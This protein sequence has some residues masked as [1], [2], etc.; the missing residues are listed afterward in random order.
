MRRWL[1]LMLL[2]LPQLA[3][4]AGI[5][6]ATLRQV[7]LPDR[8]THVL[9]G[10]PPAAVL[11]AALAPELMTGWPHPPSA[12]A[13]AF[14][15]D[16]LAALPMAPP[17]TGSAEAA[18]AITAA[19]PDLIVDYGD[20]G[21]RYV[22]A[23]EA[24]QQTTGIP[25]ILLDG[26]LSMIPA[27]LRM[28]GQALHREERAEILARFAEAV[29]TLADGSPARGTVL[30]ARGEEG[31][32]V[33]AP[34]TGATDVFTLLGWRVLAP[35]GPGT[36][37]HASVADIRALD[38]DLLVFADPAM[39]QAVSAE[40]WRS[41]RAVRTHHVLV[42]P[43]LPFGWLD[44]PPSIN[45]LAGVMWLAGTDPGTVGAIF[46]AVVYGRVLA[47]AEITALRDA[48]RPVEP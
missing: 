43:R 31:L 22:Q 34:G 7:Q 38:P 47:P 36:F 23:A 6:D 14:L 15:P 40:P 16:R 12:A 13:R 24:T 33:A 21:P 8:I 2:A 3:Q 11:L 25:T 48:A 45:R 41:L 9:P 39:R 37:R 10:G 17:V 44:G 29:L 28:L 32:A 19:A 18:A 35:D 42:A 20:V 1:L 5:T 26:R 4:G 30:A 46:N 27:V